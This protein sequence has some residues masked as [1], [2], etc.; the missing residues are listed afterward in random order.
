M[1]EEDM[2]V[3]SGTGC[4]PTASAADASSQSGI[5]DAKVSPLIQ[6]ISMMEPIVLDCPTL[7]S[8]SE[9][10]QV[11]MAISLKRIADLLCGTDQTCDIV[12]Y[13][14]NQTWRTAI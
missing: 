5:P 9:A 1:K 11:S 13:L 10:A 7:S 12:Q 8:P 4:Q 14:S 2:G 3:P 6:A